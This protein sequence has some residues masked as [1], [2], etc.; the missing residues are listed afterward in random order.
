[1][2]SSPLA[3][4]ARERV[5]PSIHRH[6]PP[7]LD[8]EIIIYLTRP[9]WLRV[10]PNRLGYCNFANSKWLA[11]PT[12]QSQNCWATREALCIPEFAKIDP[13]PPVTTCRRAA[14]ANPSYSV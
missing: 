1:M 6:N 13:E 2:V 11:I 10:V 3:T 9:T 7:V 4:L 5:F 12:V 8:P 14:T